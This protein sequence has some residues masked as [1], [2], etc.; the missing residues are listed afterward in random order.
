MYGRVCQ[1]RHCR[2]RTYW[3]KNFKTYIFRKED[4]IPIDLLASYECVCYNSHSPCRL[5]L[6]RNGTRAETRFRLS[7]KRTSPFKRAG[8]VS[9]VDYW[10]GSCAHQPAGFV[11]LVQ[12]CVLQSC[13]LYWLPTPFSCFLFTYPPVRYRVP[14]H[15]NWTLHQTVSK[16]RTHTGAT[17][18]RTDSYIRQKRKL[19]FTVPSRKNWRTSCLS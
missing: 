9:S 14:S 8:G 18:W 17:R 15:L 1:T 6:K 2:I 11:L 16:M 13:D 7:T 10:Q 12:A 4:E 19:Y 5:R 3:S